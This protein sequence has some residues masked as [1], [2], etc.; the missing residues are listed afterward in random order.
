[1]EIILA[2]ASPRRRELLGK[3]VK[4]FKVIVSGEEEKTCKT[5][6]S[7]ICLDLALQKAKAVSK[8]HFDSVV[9]GADTIVV[10][11]DKLLGKPKTVQENIEYLSALSSTSHF[12]LTGYAIIY[13]GEISCGVEKTE[14]KFT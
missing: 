1:M 4:D 13:K 9:I 5:I 11:N 12:V 14:V 10:L 8:N 7:E 3:I 2:S 6:P